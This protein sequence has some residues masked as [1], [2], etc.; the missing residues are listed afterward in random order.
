MK[1]NDNRLIRWLQSKLTLRLRLLLWFT[2]L[3]IV[4]ATSLVIVINIMAQTIVPG[5]VDL[6]PLMQP[7]G[8]SPAPGDTPLPGIIIPG[9]EASLLI[10]Q[11][12]NLVQTISIV[13]LL[14]I[15]IL[16][17]IIA[18]QMVDAALKP[19]TNLSQIVAHIDADALNQRVSLPGP[20]D[21]IKQLADEFDAMLNRLDQAFRQQS[22][23][24]ADAAH[25]LRTPLAVM[26]TNIEIV[27]MDQQATLAD[28]Q[29]TVTVLEEML[30]RLEQ[31]VNSLLLLAR[32][33]YE[34]VEDDVPLLSLLEEV[35]ADLTPLAEKQQV[36]LRLN[37][38]GEPVVPGDSVL[39]ARAFSNLIENGIRYNRPGGLVEITVSEASNQVV[40]SIA[41]NGL[42]IPAD[43]QAHVFD[44]FYRLD[45]SRSRQKGGV[46][47]GLS[48]VAHIVQL[49]NGC[50]TLQSSPGA[51][52]AFTLY[53]PNLTP[54]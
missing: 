7:N 30:D 52:S 47:L 51:G 50:I 12:L 22:R 31:L 16:G 25:E 29:E 48:I 46:G 45:L 18:Y 9:D 41:D 19:V 40:V 34:M 5:A 26:R 43:Q 21:E 49:H 39:L 42:G 3:L 53:F 14:V 24:V 27:Q 33:E 38:D 36:T 6:V 15:I 4:M 10:D 20:A 1:H 13:S 44:R 35:V 2:C 11:T 17:G 37:G 28:Y 32:Q 8:T 23:F 54:A